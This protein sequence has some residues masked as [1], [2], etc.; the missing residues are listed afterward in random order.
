MA[1][2]KGTE[3]AKLP[4]PRWLASDSLRALAASA[5]AI[6]VGEPIGIWIYG[7]DAMALVGRE[8]VAVYLITLSGML[9]A[10][11]VLTWLYFRRLTPQQLRT[12]SARRRSARDRVAF[13]L[14]G[15]GAGTWGVTILALSLG[16]VLMVALVRGL[17]TTDV[18]ILCGILL[19]SGWFCMGSMYACRYLRLDGG[20]ERGEL[21]FPDDEPRTFSDYVYFS[22]QVQ[23]TFAGSDVAIMTTRARRIVNLHSLLSFTFS[24]VV[25]ALLVSAVLTLAQR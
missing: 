7:V 15:G 6:V 13:V 19:I 3:E 16:S 25:V 17:Q 24:T 1:G 9:I 21:R 5:I 8:F 14:A 18:M 22:H 10:F 4:R 12:V 20:G 11:P 23:T 2:T